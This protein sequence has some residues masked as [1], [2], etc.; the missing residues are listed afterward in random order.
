MGRPERERITT[1][2]AREVCQR[3]KLQVTPTIAKVRDRYLLTLEE[4]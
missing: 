3:F 4:S 2:L 1:P